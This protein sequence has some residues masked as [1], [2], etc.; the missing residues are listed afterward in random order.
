MART[1]RTARQSAAGGEPSALPR[2]VTIENEA[3][4]VTYE[5]IPL[6]QVRLDPD[7]PRIR[8]HLKQLGKTAKITQGELQKIILE[9]SGVPALL[10][11]IREN[12]GLHDPIYVRHDGRVAEGNCRTSVFRFLREAQKQEKCWQTIKALRLPPTVTERQIAVLQGHMHVAGKI[13]WRAH[14]QS[15][16]LHYM[17]KTLGMNPGEIA[18]AIGLSEPKV[19]RLLLTYETMTTHVIP[20]GAGDSRKKF[21]YVLE[22]YTHKKLQDFRAKPEN[23]K[24][25]A[26]LIVGKDPKLKRGAEVRDLHRIIGNAKAEAAL[27][28]EG[29]AKAISIVGK[30]DPT[31]DSTVF[32]KLKDLTAFINK[33]LR[34]P[35]IDRLRSGKKEQQIVRDLFSAL[36]TAA[37]T[38]GL[39]MHS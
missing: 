8:E 6:D 34:K 2:T 14:E 33:N 11:S 23:V 21:S 35:E 19:K 22:F 7:N 13:T 10:R 25:F 39:L 12:R 38:A 9:I 16:H 5:E 26:S 32:R 36:K 15:G 3:I 17:H 4:P 24:L 18:A 30:S 29:F 20:K 27:K 1:A 28:K 31:A 37:E